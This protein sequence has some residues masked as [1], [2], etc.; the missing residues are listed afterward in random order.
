MF[1]KLRI[2]RGSQL[3]RYSLA[4]RP[5]LTMPSLYDAP[6]TPFRRLA[7]LATGVLAFAGCESQGPVSCLAGVA[8][9]LLIQVTDSTSGTPAAFGAVGVVTDGAFLDTLDLDGLGSTPPESLLVLSG[10]PERPG[11]YDVT[12]AKP[13]YLGWQRDGVWARAG[14]CHVATVLLSARLQPAP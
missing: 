7:A 9:A 1:T 8:P 4:I 10:P 14:D 2:A 6:L 11:I 13:G 5:S 3:K 12:I